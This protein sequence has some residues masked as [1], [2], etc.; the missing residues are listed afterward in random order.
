MTNLLQHLWLG[1]NEAQY[2]A[3]INVLFPDGN[4]PPGQTLH[5]AALVDEGVIV[6]AIW[7]S[8][9]E[10]DA[11]VSEVLIPALPIEG[12]L[13]GAPQERAGVAIHLQTT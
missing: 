5:A 7:D 9:E 8:K 11:F 6:T 3:S 2:H 10:A 13:E 1:G 12:G 4:L